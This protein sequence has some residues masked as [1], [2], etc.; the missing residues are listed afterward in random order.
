MNSKID[1]NT[2]L[3]I[4]KRVFSFP[5]EC[6][7]KIVFVS[8]PKTMPERIN[9]KKNILIFSGLKVTRPAIKAAQA[10]KKSIM[11]V[12]QLFSQ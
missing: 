4:Q 12:Y 7:K 5:D 11:L 2:T 10:D 8:F 6:V 1:E 3:C 9:S